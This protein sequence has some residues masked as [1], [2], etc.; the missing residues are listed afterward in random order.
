MIITPQTISESIQGVID[1]A[2][3]ETFAEEP[4]F[5]ADLNEQSWLAATNKTLCVKLS[6]CVLGVLLQKKYVDGA[7][8]RCVV[9][10]IID[11]LTH[12]CSKLATG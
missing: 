11:M 8:C 12:T 1:F 4:K 2:R 5:F 6:T 10:Y 3:T 7:F 9:T